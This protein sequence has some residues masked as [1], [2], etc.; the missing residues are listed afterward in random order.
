MLVPKLSALRPPSGGAAFRRVR[1]RAF[2]LVELLTVISII[3]ALAA[4]LTP[5]VGKAR[6]SARST[7][8]IANMRQI[9]AAMLLYAH[10]NKD[11]LPAP[12]DPEGS[13]SATWIAALHPYTGAPFPTG[14]GPIAV[15]SVN[16]IFVCP[17]WSFVEAADFDKV[18]SYAMWAES[19]GAGP[20]WTRQRTISEIRD[21]SKALLLIEHDDTA[22]TGS[23]AAWREGG[24][25]LSTPDARGATR[26]HAHANYL[27]LDG[28]VTGKTPGMAKTCFAH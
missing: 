27:F 6:A 12:G 16:P 1:K 15:A 11:R 25:Y 17:E 4:I 23:S 7:Q 19:D 24:D 26:H 28:H 14:A 5:V 3:G 9:G 22:F 2:S 13:Q 18:R 20:D 21:P 10:D 8:C